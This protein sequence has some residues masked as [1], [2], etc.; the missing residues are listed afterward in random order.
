MTRD[1]GGILIRDAT[2]ADFPALLALNLASEQFL[3]PLSPARLVA[4]H[5]MADR[6]RVLCE[7]ELV[8][9]FLLAFRE[10]TAYDSP[11]YRW[12]AAR[13][14]QFL[15]IDRVVIAGE[16][17]GRQYGQRLYADLCAHARACGIGRITCEFD[18]EPPNEG[19]RRFHARLGFREV[20]SQRIRG[21]AKAVSLQELL[22]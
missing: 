14:P 8:R 21:G 5:A 9:G 17:R 13:Y 2:P 15:Y 12:F 3:S 4:L 10:A 20:G 22:L 18:T 11:N 6:N 19:S 7:G 16:A 1:V